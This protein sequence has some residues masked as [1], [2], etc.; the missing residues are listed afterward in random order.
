VTRSP[1]RPVFVLMALSTLWPASAAAQPTERLY[2]EACDGGDVTACNVFGLMLETGQG[3]PPD[4]ARAATFYRRACEGGELVGCTNVGLLHSAG[5]AQDTARAA[6]FF[7]I[8]CE[9]GEQLGCTLLQAL[10]DVA[11]AVP[12]ERYDKLG[13]IGDI[14]TNRPLA[15]AVVDLPGLGVRAI[16][17]AEGRFVLTGLPAGRHAIRA[18]RLGYDQL[19]GVV[20]VPG[21]P[22][23]VMLMTLT[24]VVDPSAAG[25][26]V[27]RVL[28]PGER[29]LSDVEVSVLGQER[30]RTLSNQQGRFTIRD[31]EPGLVVVRFVRIGYAPRTATLVVQPG[32]TAEVSAA[33]AVQPIELEPVEVTIRS[34]DLERAGF[35]DRASRGF[36]THFAPGDLERMQPVLVSDALRGRVP[37]VTVVQR[38]IGG[39][40]YLVGR[41]GR[42]FTLGDCV[43]PVWIDGVRSFDNDIDQISAGSIAAVEVYQGPGTPPQYGFDACGAVLIWT[44]RGN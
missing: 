14:A 39:E 25:Q 26:V 17:D 35:Y 34:L 24:D 43:L 36:G 42:S 33:M 13:R 10:E 15:D 12:T 31:V 27:G 5:T 28:E 44:R 6:G 1:K 41:R 23:F 21:N 38:V 30:A 29:G 2:Q 19:V 32:R 16:S 22:D 4:L 7:R 18:E 11:R 3:V 37:G 20:E 9:G 40:S 8:A